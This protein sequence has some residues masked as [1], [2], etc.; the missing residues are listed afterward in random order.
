MSNII[1]SKLDSL[2]K[3]LQSHTIKKLCV[4]CTKNPTDILLNTILK[5]K[6]YYSDFDIIIIDSDSNNFTIF[7]KISKDIKI[8]FIKN[9]NWELGA[10]YYAYNKYNMYDIYMFIQD[11]IV[12]I[13]KIEFDYNNIMNTNYF[14]SFHFNEN[15]NKNSKYKTLYNTLFENTDL[16]FISNMKNKNKNITGTM[17][18]SF[19][20]NKYIT[21]Q[22][23]KLEQ[24][25]I[26]KNI[27]YKS[28]INSWLSERTIGI[29]ADKY[30]KKRIDIKPYFKK[31]HLKRDY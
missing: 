31:Y 3:I 16:N 28:K 11:S 10:W 4:I 18:S 30:S 8:E 27:L 6:Q 20:T 24:I 12:P 21:K 26:D 19:I 7:Q 22:I 29:I 14:Y 9:K 15:M 17:H 1:N 23:L 2:L 5:I 13:K 25:Y